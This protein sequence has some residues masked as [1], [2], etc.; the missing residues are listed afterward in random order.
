M[1]SGV[2]VDS[3]IGCV[4]LYLSKVVGLSFLLVVSEG[5]RCGGFSG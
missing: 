5:R 4:S 2:D 1:L 3:G